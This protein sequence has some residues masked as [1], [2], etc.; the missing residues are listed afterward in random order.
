M[1]P[2][3][4]H[5]MPWAPRTAWDGWLAIA[6]FPP[7][8]AIRWIKAHF[9]RPAFAHG[10]TPLAAV[11]GFGETAETLL[12]WATGESVATYRREVETVNFTAT[13]AP[14]ALDL[15]GRFRLAGDAPEYAF[16]VAFPD[17]GVSATFDVRTG[18]PIWWTRVG[19]FL[20]YLG[21]H[22]EMA[23]TLNA[24]G[25]PT[26]QS[27]T[28]TLEHVMG[29]ALP[30]DFTRALFS[31]HFHWDVLCF[32]TP[33]SPLDSAA[34]LAL[35]R[36]GAH[37]AASEGGDA[38]PRA[39]GALL[40]GAG[41]RLL[42][43]RPRRGAGRARDRRADPLVRAD[44]AQRRRLRLRRDGRDAAGAAGPRRR[45][46]RIR[47]RRDVGPVAGG[48]GRAFRD[49]LHRGRRLRRQPPGA[50][51]MTEAGIARVRLP[52]PPVGV[53]I[54]GADD[55]GMAAERFTGVSYCEAVTRAGR[56]GA[57]IVDAASIQSCKW[58]PPVL[59]FK[60]RESDFEKGLAPVLPPTD[61]LLLAP[62]DR[63]PEDAPPDVVIVRGPRA[64]ITALL[65]EVNESET[66]AE[67]AR[68]PH[69]DASALAVIR[70][71]ATDTAFHRAARRFFSGM[72]LMPGWKAA[73]AVLFK[74]DLVTRAFEFV[75]RRT[76]ADMSVCRNSTVIPRVTGKVNVSY[77]CAGG[78]TWGG[79]DGGEFTSG[80]PIALYRRIADRIEWE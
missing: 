72:R 33:D 70:R 80:W 54:G 68:G 24:G 55:A 47:L 37:A 50:R 51:P 71:G 69:V 12:A 60:E 43:G 14:M 74:S 62:I 61:S 36:R 29:A 53:R 18:F 73:T 19:R 79:N 64:A 39:G 5:M 6:I 1:Y 27:G 46:D 4:R 66:A 2:Q 9:Y 3:P 78:V 25:E 49:G 77:F 38:V 8:S 48:P 75:I 11:E 76:M 10:K 65:T 45:D 7:E 41:R 30:F 34:G 56:N 20:H 28:G 58:A 23:V 40:E 17:E 35:M 57:L 22:S 67:Y 59:G 31:L 16:N 42:A 52:G 63:F 21:Q 13:D 15:P 32:H 44:E 26:V